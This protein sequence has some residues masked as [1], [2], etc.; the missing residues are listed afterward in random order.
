[1][2]LLERQLLDPVSCST[3]ALR[4]EAVGK[5]AIRVLKKGLDSKDSEVRFYSAEALAYLDDPSCAQAL[6]DSAKNEPAFRAFALAA[7]SALNEVHASDALRDLFDVPSAETR[8]G[9]F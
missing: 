2:D 5:D 8:Y 7:L 9:A 4:L 3:A 6:A 1:L